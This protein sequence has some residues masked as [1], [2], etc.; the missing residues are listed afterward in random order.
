MVKVG[1]GAAAVLGDPLRRRFIPG[2]QARGF[3]GVQVEE[4]KEEGE[5]HGAE[6]GM[7]CFKSKSVSADARLG[8]SIV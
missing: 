4:R 1:S 6:V 2:N 7:P 8:L 3:Q 5:T